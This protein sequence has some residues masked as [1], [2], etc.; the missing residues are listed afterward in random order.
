MTTTAMT[1]VPATRP[2][3]L[4]RKL[5]VTVGVMVFCAFLGAVG[6]IVGVSKRPAAATPGRYVGFATLVADNYLAGKP[7]DVPAA[8]GIDTQLGRLTQAQVS[9]QASQPDSHVAP[10]P[11]ANVTFE[12]AVDHAVTAKGKATGRSVETDTFLVQYTDGTVGQLA[13]VVDGTS[14][15]PELGALPTLLPGPPRAPA[16][17]PVGSGVPVAQL[18]DALPSGLQF[19]V[20]QWA[21][22]FAA[23]NQVALYQLTGDTATA[24]FR[25]L[26][27]YQVVGT[28]QIVSATE[29]GTS[30]NPAKSMVVTITMVMQSTSQPTVVAS[31][32]YDLLVDNLQNHLPNIVAW[33]PAGSG[34]TLIPFENGS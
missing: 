21:A 2:L 26:G 19:Q 34:G 14:A 3:T 18:A 11:V 23:D 17:N 9:A 31:T 7:L 22:A 13:V 29:P 5:K 25:G 16:V 20:N 32:S 27:G 24:T 4:P 33:G 12:S 28:P 8:T 10:I 6:F 1:A 30:K 15:G